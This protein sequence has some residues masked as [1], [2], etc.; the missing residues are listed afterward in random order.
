MIIH[1]QPPFAGRPFDPTHSGKKSAGN[2]SWRFEQTD[3]LW[4]G[5]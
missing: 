1:Q 2:L 3:A 4:I 5:R